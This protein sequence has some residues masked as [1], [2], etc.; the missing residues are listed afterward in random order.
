MFMGWRMGDDLA[1]FATMQDGMLTIDVLTGT[2]LHDTIGFVNTHIAG[3]I[4][5]WFLQQLEHHQ[6]PISNIVAAGL[7]V[8]LIRI[9]QESKRKRG[10]TFEWH[11]DG[12]VATVDRKYLAQLSENHTWIPA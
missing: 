6:I 12:M 10:I 5:A 1:I 7:T 8:R 9:A 11:C 2:C 4:S 3:E